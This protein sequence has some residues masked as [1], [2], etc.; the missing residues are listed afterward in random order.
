M[1]ANVDNKHKW[2]VQV[3]RVF[4]A[5]GSIEYT[6]IQCVDNITKDN[7][8][9]TAKKFS[10]SRRIDLIIEILSIYNHKDITKFKGLLKKVKL[11]SEQRNLIAHNPLVLDIYQNDKNELL[12]KEKIH[13]LR[14]PNKHIR[15]DELKKLA[16][17][18]E[19]LSGELY[20]CAID[21]YNAVRN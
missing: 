7:I 16:E 14:N 5:F 4:I 9:E 13:S 18:S 15:L 21:V 19:N 1:V 6:T 10:L 3:G 12:I 11:L 8:L 17:D 20:G 2:A